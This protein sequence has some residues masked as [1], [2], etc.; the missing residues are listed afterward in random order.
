MLLIGGKFRGKF[1]ILNLFFLNGLGLGPK[2]ETR[3]KNKILNFPKI[4]LTYSTDDLDPHGATLTK[5]V[6][7][8]QKHFRNIKVDR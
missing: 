6:R 1:K 5:K 4:T 3:R 7:N 8:N 2:K